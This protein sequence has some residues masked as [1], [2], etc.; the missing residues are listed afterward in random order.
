MNGDLLSGLNNLC[1]NA[2]L[3]KISHNRETFVCT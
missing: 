2:D 3:S 1:D